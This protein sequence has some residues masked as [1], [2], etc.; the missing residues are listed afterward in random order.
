MFESIGES[1]WL[2]VPPKFR[3]RLVE[4]PDFGGWHQKT[5]RQVRPRFVSYTRKIKKSSHITERTNVTLKKAK[6]RKMKISAARKF[7]VEIPTSAIK[8]PHLSPPIFSSKIP[9]FR[10]IIPTFFQKSPRF[11]KKSQLFEVSTKIFI[12]F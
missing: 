8:N 5:R 12:I 3:G 1:L 7:R 9:T 10:K 2:F 11:K 4:P 6:R